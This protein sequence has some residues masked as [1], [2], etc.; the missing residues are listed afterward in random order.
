MIY[1]IILIALGIIALIFNKKGIS[2]KTTL[3]NAILAPIFI[4]WGLVGIIILSTIRFSVFAEN[5][6]YWI[7][8]IAGSS[9]EILI[10]LFFVYRHLKLK[11][12]NTQNNILFRS[13]T[14]LAILAVL[15][16]IA[17]ILSK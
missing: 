1:A 4:V 7:L 11:K 13:Q 2:K 8:L 14:I 16:G 6:N 9:M 10:A 3:R 12:E 15:I 5:S 17:T